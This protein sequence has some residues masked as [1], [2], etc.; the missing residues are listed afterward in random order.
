MGG[1]RTF[2]KGGSKFLI[3][4]RGTRKMHLCSKRYIR[5]TDINTSKRSSSVQ[6]SFL[7][8]VLCKIRNS[9]GLRSTLL[10][11]LFLSVD[12]TSDN[13]S[14]NFYHTHGQYLI[15][16]MIE[17]ILKMSL[18]ILSLFLLCSEY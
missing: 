12:T 17:Q 8:N 16:Q 10:I 5:R 14:E 2:K 4:E 7:S 13:I 11:G 3:Q 6:E 18:K 1:Y 9:T 15:H